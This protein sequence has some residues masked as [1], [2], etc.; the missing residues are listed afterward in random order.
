MFVKIQLLNMSLTILTLFCNWFM[1]IQLQAYNW[2]A[3]NQWWAAPPTIPSYLACWVFDE[4]QDFVRWSGWSTFMLP[5][6]VGCFGR[7]KWNRKTSWCSHYIWSETVCFWVWYVWCMGASFPHVGC[8]YLLTRMFVLIFLVMVN[9]W[10]ILG[11]KGGYVRDK[12]SD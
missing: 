8:I 2:K 11:E 10:L 5:A 4:C 1:K 9:L 3:N 7:K 6:A 12:C